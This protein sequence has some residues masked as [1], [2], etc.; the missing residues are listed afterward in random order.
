MARSSISTHENKSKY[1]NWYKI[2]LFIS[3]YIV[4][5]QISELG[6]KNA[7]ALRLGVNIIFL[8]GEQDGKL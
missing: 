8:K 4:Y 7:P 2:K 5:N 6:V 1:K 3:Y